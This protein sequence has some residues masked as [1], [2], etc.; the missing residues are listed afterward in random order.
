MN[1]FQY[2]FR[3]YFLVFILLL[4]VLTS[5]PW[6]LGELFTPVSLSLAV[7]SLFCYSFISTVWNE[8]WWKIV[9]IITL[10][11]ALLMLLSPTTSLKIKAQN[12]FITG[13]Y[14]TFFSFLMGN[15][16]TVVLFSKA[17][18]A[19]L[20]CMAVS[21][22]I[23]FFLY[24]NGLVKNPL[25]YIENWS[26]TYE[27]VPFAIYYPFSNVI[28]T[29]Y[30]SGSFFDGVS[31]LR[32]TSFLREPGLS[33]IILSFIT[34]W[35]LTTYP[36]NRKTIVFLVLAGMLCVS[37]AYLPSVLL[38]IFFALVVKY[39]RLINIP[40][41]MLIILLI[42]LSIAILAIVFTPGV[43]LI[44]KSIAH[45]SSVDD[46]ISHLF[47]VRLSFSGDN[48]INSLVFLLTLIK[49]I[50]LYFVSKNKKTS[51][52][53]VLLYLSGLHNDFHNSLTEAIFIGL[54]FVP[55]K[56]VEQCRVL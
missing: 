13:V 29:Y 53:L 16:S 2:S 52:G 42:V 45:Q 55:V 51:L 28:G 49:Y 6:S 14:F 38:A 37:T 18:V 26:K 47:G 56:N 11:T 43:G 12:L 7:I 10:M 46:R 17:L 15:R 54:L 19:F 34:Y 3:E 31:A 48:F 20:L 39:K 50:M 21:N 25:I 33:S 22:V 24:T 1:K 36:E 27:Y 9:A 44:D 35:L 40:A 32:L 23:T 30:L 41:S 4:V 8:P 5:R